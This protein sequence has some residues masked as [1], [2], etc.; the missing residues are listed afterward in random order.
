M[1]KVAAWKPEGGAGKAG[2]GSGADAGVTLPVAR[3]VKGVGL[4]PT[5]PKQQLFKEADAGV[6][7]TRWGEG[8]DKV[9]AGVGRWCGF[10]AGVRH[11]SS[12]ACGRSM[13]GKPLGWKPWG[14]P[15]AYVT[16]SESTTASTTLLY[17]LYSYSRSA[18]G[19]QMMMGTAQP[20][21]ERG[22]GPEWVWGVGE[23]QEGEGA[24]RGGARR[25]ASRQARQTG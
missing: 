9:A 24:R 6:M 13:E 4:G 18:P 16:P 1:T 5:R 14:K 15:K 12:T 2:S 17:G 25:R 3:H 8:V 22:E 20:L 19:V 7:A 23:G 21:Q 11:G 10:G